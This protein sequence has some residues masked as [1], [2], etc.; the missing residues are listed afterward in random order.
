MEAIL[1]FEFA[2]CWDSKRRVMQQKK[3]FPL[4]KQPA[5]VV[6]PTLQA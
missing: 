6:L 3:F 1:L 5:I 2:T 4:F